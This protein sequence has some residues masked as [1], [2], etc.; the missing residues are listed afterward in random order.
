MILLGIASGIKYLHS[1]SI[2]HN[3]I[4]GDNVL[5]DINSSGKTRSI[6]ADLGKAC[7]IRHAKDYSHMKQ[8]K[9]KFIQ[10]H[11]HIAPDMVMGHCKQSK[12]SDIYSAGRVIKAIN[13]KVLK[14][15]VL[16]KYSSLCMEYVCMSRPTT[17]DFYI[18]LFNLFNK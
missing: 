12:Y 2:L 6:I 4:K 11:C 3:D 10:N 9:K 7:Y 5:I 13:E 8:D 17:D 1:M 14:V 18:F 15:P 16:C